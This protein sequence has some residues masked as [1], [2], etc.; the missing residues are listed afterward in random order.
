MSLR[1]RLNVQSL[2]GRDNP[3]GPDLID[4]FTTETTTTGT[5]TTETESSGLLITVVTT[6]IGA[7]V[8]T[9]SAV[10]VLGTTDTSGLTTLNSIYKVSL[11]P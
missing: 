6:T 3:S 2:E 11:L 1:T 10:Q 4:P 9:T 5:A 8:D 7:I